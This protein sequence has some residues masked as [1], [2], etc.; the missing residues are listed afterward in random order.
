MILNP[1]LSISQ[2]PVDPDPLAK[3][4]P[5][6]IISV[7]IF[8]L[9]IAIIIILRIIFGR[10]G[11]SLR[12]KGIR[13]FIS[14]AVNDFNR[15]RIAEIAKYLQKQKE[16]SHVYYCENDLTGNI[17]D[18]MNKTVP[19]CQLLV[20]ISSDN[21]LKSD[22]CMN[23][24]NLA[25][26]HNIEITPVLGVNLKWDDLDKLNIKRELGREYDPMEFEKFCG[27]LSSYIRKF[28]IDLERDILEKER[29]K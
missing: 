20:F 24:I 5:L 6:I 29:K 2:V 10:R 8:V 15:Y 17:D 21:S 7:L 11:I 25:R 28:K 13:V 3:Y 4:L 19:R 16:I 14:H 18:W 27:D 9:V 22:D 23:E 1:I 26:K 12:G